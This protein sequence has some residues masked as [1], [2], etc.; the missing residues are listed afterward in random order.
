[1]PAFRVKL[2]A[3]VDVCISACSICPNLETHHPGLSLFNTRFF[4]YLFCDVVLK[5]CLHKASQS[6]VCSKT[7][8]AGGLFTAMA[9]TVPE[10]RVS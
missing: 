8:L 4:F 9:L 10:F 1:V 5:R 6:F 2:G 3:N 7:C